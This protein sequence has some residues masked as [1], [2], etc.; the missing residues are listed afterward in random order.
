MD[1]HHHHHHHRTTNSLIRLQCSGALNR[2][3][4][5][6]SPRS[7][8]TLLV[9]RWYVLNGLGQ[10]IA[11]SAT[12]SNMNLHNKRL[13]METSGVIKRLCLCGCAR[14]RQPN[15]WWQ[16]LASCE[17][18]NDLTPL[19]WSHHAPRHRV[20]WLARRASLVEGGTRR[21]IRQK[22]APDC[23]RTGVRRGPAKCSVCCRA[24]DPGRIHAVEVGG[25]TSESRQQRP[26]CCAPNSTTSRAGPPMHQH[27]R[28]PPT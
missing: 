26:C 14:V 15:C 4:I 6:D 8:L 28:P 1:H 2:G 23:G 17:L 3:L 19:N 7:G 10:L 12:F 13:T 22:H 27:H 18:L 25:R 9:A 24:M 16:R 11:R 21:P 20:R 5:G